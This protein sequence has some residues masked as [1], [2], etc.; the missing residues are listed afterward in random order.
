MKYLLLISLLL[1]LGTSEATEKEPELSNG[2][3]KPAFCQKA[4]CPKYEVEKQYD[5]FELRAYEAIRWVR[6]PLESD[7]FGL[8][9][10]KSFRRLFK[11]ITGSN[12]EEMKIDM[13]VPVVI[14]VPLNQPPAGNSTMS[15]FVPHEVENA[16]QP[17]D[18]KVYL[19]NS[20]AL[21]VYV[22]SFGGYALDPTF[23][24]EAQFLAEQLRA[25]GLEFED[26]F[27]L[28]SGYNDPFTLLN[29]HNEVWV[30]A[31]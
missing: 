15:F 2:Y 14:Y 27:Y 24:K 28:R 25:L 23:F 30:I 31:K 1:V 9:M 22:R 10:V 11:Y 16:P 29:R 7:F 12:V 26:S 5:N 8:E 3:Q 13:T 19:D 20:P 21:N 17:T 18:P 4:D 6:T